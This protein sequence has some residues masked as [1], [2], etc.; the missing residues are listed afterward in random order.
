MEAK[1]KLGMDF[2]FK[3]KRCMEYKHILYTFLLSA[4]TQLKMRFCVEYKHHVS[5]PFHALS[6]NA[7][8]KQNVAI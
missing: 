2:T 6:C 3:K 1:G 5:H 7:F 8:H 4:E